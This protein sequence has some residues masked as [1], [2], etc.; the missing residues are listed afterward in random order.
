MLLHYQERFEF[1]FA[2][3]SQL[4]RNNTINQRQITNKNYIQTICIYFNLRHSKFIC[5]NETTEEEKLFKM[6]IIYLYFYKSMNGS[7]YH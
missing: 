3:D 5:Q 6:F 2:T 1:C 4:I 7:N